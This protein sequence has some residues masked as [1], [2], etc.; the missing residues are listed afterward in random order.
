MFADVKANH[1]VQTAFSLHVHSKNE[2][3]FV[4][5]SLNWDSLSIII[6]L[7]LVRGVP[8]LN[9]LVISVHVYCRD[10]PHHQSIAIHAC[11]QQSRQQR[12]QLAHYDVLTAL[13]VSAVAGIENGQGSCGD[14][15]RL[16]PELSSGVLYGIWR[17]W[18]CR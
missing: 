16:Q 7:P 18:G 10:C 1:E 13:L 12:L 9:S 11:A 5:S 6:C 8:H 14:F 17:T 2:G 15:A 3:I 4:T